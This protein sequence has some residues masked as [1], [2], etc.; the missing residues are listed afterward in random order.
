[1]RLLGALVPLSVITT[2][3]AVRVIL[4]C[5][6]VERGIDVAIVRVLRVAGI[7][8]PTSFGANFID[9]F[10]ACA[11]LGVQLYVWCV[12]AV[13]AGARGFIVSGGAAHAHM[14]PQISW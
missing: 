2:A 13:V 3:V 5:R 9:T 11:E 7:R 4:G 14:I 12:T 10:L 8:S 1:M 6:V